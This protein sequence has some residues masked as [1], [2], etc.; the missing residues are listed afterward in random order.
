MD[1]GIDA[2]VSITAEHEY[3]ESYYELNHLLVMITVV[4]VHSSEGF[5]IRCSSGKLR[6]KVV[7]IV[8]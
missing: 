1:E 7:L 8:S 4:T 6:I 5:T 3:S 2:G